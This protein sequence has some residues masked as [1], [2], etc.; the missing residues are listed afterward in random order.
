ML[1]KMGESLNKKCHII[2]HGL[3]GTGHQF[4][5]IFTSLILHGIKDYYF[6]GLEFIKK[7]FKFQHITNYESCQVKDYFIESIKNFSKD[8]NQNRVSYSNTI[9]SHE[10]YNVPLNYSE[11]TLY[12][13]DNA[14]YFD[15]IGL[16]EKEKTQHREN[17][18]KFKKYFI[19]DKLPNNRLVEN[20]IVIHIRMGDAMETSRKESIN[21]FINNFKILIDKLKKDYPEYKIYIHSDG[22]LDVF[23]QEGL[24]F[25]DKKTNILQILSDFIHSKIFICSNSGLSIICT[26]LGNHDKIIVPG[27]IN[28]SL[29][30]N[31]ITIE[32]Y[33]TKIDINNP[34]EV[35]NSSLTEIIRRSGFEL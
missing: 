20:N 35:K 19:N 2:Q 33:L 21:N 22:K 10:I 11:R 16:N 23:D 7:R 34:Y 3:D 27:D 6:D 18:K 15:R 28:H 24:V 1:F 8:L 31:C 9:H 14:Y 25:F 12:S 26:F 30:E 13:I 29:P 17:I 4:Y 5:G 32:N